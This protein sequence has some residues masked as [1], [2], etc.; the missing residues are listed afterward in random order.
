VN[1]TL[2]MVNFSGATADAGDKYTGLDRL[3]PK[4]G[5]A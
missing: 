4:K 3:A 2:S 5:Q 1:V